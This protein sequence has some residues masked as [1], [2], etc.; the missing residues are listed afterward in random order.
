M[1]RKLY[2]PNADKLQVSGSKVSPRSL[3]VVI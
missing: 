2:N 3:S 1:F